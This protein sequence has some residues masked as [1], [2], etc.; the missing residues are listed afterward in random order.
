MSRPHQHIEKQ[1]ITTNWEINSNPKT[2]VD[3]KF[4]KSMI[5]KEVDTNFYIE[6]CKEINKTEN[7]HLNEEVG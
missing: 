5:D 7:Q 3:G 4:D 2:I 1:F 6:C